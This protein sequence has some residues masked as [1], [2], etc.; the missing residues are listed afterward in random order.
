MQ[1]VSGGSRTKVYL[2]HFAFARDY[3]LPTQTSRNI[4]F[5]PVPIPTLPP[6]APT[7]PPTAAPTLPPTAAPTLPP[8]APTLWPPL[9]TASPTAPT[10]PP[11]APTLPTLPPTAAP[12]LPPTAP[13]LWPPLPTASPTR[14]PNQSSNKHHEISKR[15][16]THDRDLKLTPVAKRTKVLVLGQLDLPRH[17]AAFYSDVVKT[18]ST[19]PPP[20]PGPP[21]ASQPPCPSISIT[22]PEADMQSKSCCPHLRLFTHHRYLLVLVFVNR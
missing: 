19:I 16:L 11:T 21:A 15:G 22:L 2:S 17:Q 18:S 10:L 20:P 9:P 14:P 3:I 13:T 6:T 5:Y 7:L 1:G 4:A 8:T 12:T